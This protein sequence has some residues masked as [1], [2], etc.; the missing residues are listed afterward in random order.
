M[1]RGRRALA[2]TRMRR[3]SAPGPRSRSCRLGAAIPTPRAAPSPARCFANGPRHPRRRRGRHR[4]RAAAVQRSGRAKRRAK[5]GR[6]PQ[7]RRRRLVF[8]C[9]R[10]DAV[11]AAGLGA[12]RGARHRRRFGTV[13][14]CNGPSLLLGR[15]CAP[16]RRAPPPQRRCRRHPNANGRAPNRSG[17]PLLR[18]SGGQGACLRSASH[19]KGCEPR[20]SGAAPCARARHQP[21]CVSTTGSALPRRRVAHICGEQSIATLTGIDAQVAEP[22]TTAAATPSAARWTPAAA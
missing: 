7:V 1:T 19:R 13:L 9:A 12:T 10:R 20:K 21:A 17:R 18:L 22:R 6:H 5:H 11:S 14:G 4:R 2:A 16:P 15:T 8:R 3:Y